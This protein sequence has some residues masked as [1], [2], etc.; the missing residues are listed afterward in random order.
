[1]KQEN[2]LK[3]LQFLHRMLL[4]GQILFAALAFFLVYTRNITSF[5]SHLD[6]TLQIVALIIS[7]AGLLVGSSLFKKKVRQAR[8]S[9]G[10]IKTKTGS[11]RTASVIQWALLEGP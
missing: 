11:Y 5:L 8:E 7:L 1:M 10:D 4:F 9:S 2:T 6:G 3:I